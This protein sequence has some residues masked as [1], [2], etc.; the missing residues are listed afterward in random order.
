MYQYD[1]LIEWCVVLKGN[2]VKRVKPAF[3]SIIVGAT[4]AKTTPLLFS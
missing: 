1:A 3:S 2:V 4:V